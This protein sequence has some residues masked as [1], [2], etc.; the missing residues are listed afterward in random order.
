AAF[1]EVSLQET[2]TPVTL[3]SDGTRLITVPDGHYVEMTFTF[4]IDLGSGCFLGV[5]FEIHDGLNQSANLLGVFCGFHEDKEY[6]F[7]S[8]GRHMWLKYHRSPYLSDNFHVKYTAKQNNVTVAPVLTQV[9]TIQFV[10]YNH[11]SFLWCPAEGA[12]APVIFWRKNGIVVQNTTSVKYILVIVKGNNETYSCEVKNND[13]LTKKELDLYIEKRPAI[14]N[15]C[16]VR[17]SLTDEDFFL[18][19]ILS[20]DQ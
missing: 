18:D 19:F 3:E 15:E 14:E 13:Q 4:P 6:V 8:S 16:I 17:I 12:P 1:A 7:R 5:Y 9:K 2:G 11:S 10:L 20:V